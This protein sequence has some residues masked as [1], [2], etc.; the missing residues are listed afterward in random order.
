MEAADLNNM[1]VVTVKTAA[2]YLQELQDFAF[3]QENPELLELITRSQTIV[4]DFV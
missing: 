1:P 2:T 3:A 4:E